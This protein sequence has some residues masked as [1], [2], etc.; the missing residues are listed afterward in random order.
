VY[1]FVSQNALSNSGSI[2]TISFVGSFHNIGANVQMWSGCDFGAREKI[3]FLVKS[4]SENIIASWSVHQSNANAKRFFPW[5]IPPANAF[6]LEIQSTC[7]TQKH[8]CM[9]QDNII[10]WLD[11]IVPGPTR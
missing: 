7:L 10:P 1:W 11:P 9:G 8:S 2:R 5:A 6:Q 3:L 4:A